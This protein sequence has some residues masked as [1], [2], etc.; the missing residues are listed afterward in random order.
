M[1]VYVS[2]ARQGPPFTVLMIG[3]VMIKCCLCVYDNQRL[4]VTV[5]TVCFIGRLDTNIVN[6]A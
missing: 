5:A 3:A 1:A 2:S 4:S 6:A